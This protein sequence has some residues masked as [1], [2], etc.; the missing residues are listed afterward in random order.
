[1]SQ[2]HQ[3]K[4]SKKSKS[5]EW[6]TPDWFIPSVEKEYRMKFEVDVACTHRNCKCMTGITNALKDDWNI[7]SVHGKR[8][9]GDVWCNP[10]NSKLQLFLP[11]AYQ[12]WTKYG[13]RIF[14]IVPAN[15]MSSKGFW[16]GVEIPRRK[17]ERITYEPVFKRIAFLDNGKKPKFSARNAYIVII[18]GKKSRF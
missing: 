15:V 11:R 8:K 14:M 18:W 5:D 16:N 7:K 12:Q 9:W 1:M 10:P 17:G 2:L 6:W 13:M 4:R 3:R